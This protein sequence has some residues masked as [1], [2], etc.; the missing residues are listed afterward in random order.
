MAKSIS[1]FHVV[2]LT[3]HSHSQW[4]NKKHYT[5]LSTVLKMNTSALDNIIFLYP[6]T[7]SITELLRQSY[8]S[9][10]ALHMKLS[11]LHQWHTVPVP[12]T[13][14]TMSWV[15]DCNSLS[16]CC[17]VSYILS[18]T[19]KGQPGNA[20]NEHFLFY[21]QF[22]CLCLYP[23][24]RVWTQSYTHKGIEQTLDTL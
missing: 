15:F 17:R 8:K 1:L 22:K 6:S 18:T 12:S 21:G 13:S 20:K 5:K 7:S 11:Q 24:T 10:E 16:V 19:Y 2:I 14:M 23:S 9:P 4:H 3:L